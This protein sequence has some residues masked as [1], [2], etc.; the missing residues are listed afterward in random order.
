MNHLRAGRDLSQ[1][2]SQRAAALYELVACPP[3]ITLTSS[4]MASEEGDRAE[5]IRSEQ[6]TA[7]S[8]DLEAIR[9]LAAAADGDS[10]I[11]AEAADESAERPDIT[12]ATA[13]DTTT[14][15]GT[16]SAGNS[17]D[18]S[19]ADKGGDDS[20]SSAAQTSGGTK[21][22]PPESGGE[23][24]AEDEARHNHSHHHEWLAERHAHTRVGTEFQ[25]AAL[26]TPHPH[27]SPTGA[28]GNGANGS[29]GAK[30]DVKDVTGGKE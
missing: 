4:K 19:S 7:A 22:R 27:H 18:A 1:V 2:M 12:S 21:K 11:E 13:M 5:R 8:E 15:G 20:K 9:A 26:P 16:T 10:A 14:E 23:I 17:V 28:G 25:V 6:K 3:S 29:G 30:L 24:H